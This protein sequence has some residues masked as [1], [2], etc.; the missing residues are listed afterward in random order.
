MFI[1]MS[2][3]NQKWF[4]SFVIKKRRDGSGVVLKQKPASLKQLLSDHVLVQDRVT[5]NIFH[6]AFLDML[7][8]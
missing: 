1:F 3:M 8:V 5:G 6:Q 4:I 2:M 7:S